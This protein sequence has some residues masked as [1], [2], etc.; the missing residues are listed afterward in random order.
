MWLE[1]RVDGMIETE[2]VNIPVIRTIAYIC[3]M[4]HNLMDK[5]LEELRRAQKNE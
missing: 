2:K 3:D 5:K 1:R 4:C